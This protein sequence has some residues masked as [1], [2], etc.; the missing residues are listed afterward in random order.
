[1][2]CPF[3]ATKELLVDLPNWQLGNFRVYWLSYS[4]T[5]FLSQLSHSHF[6]P[7][8]LPLLTPPPW[9]FKSRSYRRKIMWYY[10]FSPSGIFSPLPIRGRFPTTYNLYLNKPCHLNTFIF[11]S[12]LNFPTFNYFI[13]FL[14]NVC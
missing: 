14:W 11:S 1:M 5:S 13:I 3:L 6:L 9:V 8:S 4:L 10:N 2:F 7:T 12:A